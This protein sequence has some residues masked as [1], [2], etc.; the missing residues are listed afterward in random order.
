MR[1]FGELYGRLDSTTS[2]NA[3]VDHLVDYFEAAPAADAAWAVYVLTGR[4]L[5]RPITTTQMRAWT[6]D[7]AGVPEWLFEECYIKVGDLAETI[8]LLLDEGSETEDR[9]DDPLHAW[10]ED[11]IP[12][13]ENASETRQR[14]LVTDWW[15]GLDRMGT[16]VL[17]KLMMGAFRVGVASGLVTRA[18]S[19]FGGVD[20]PVIQHRLA[21][22]WEPSA[23]YFER[24]VSE[25]TGESDR[26]RPY[27]YFLATPMDQMAGD[28]ADEDPDDWLVEW[29][30]DGIRAQLVV[31]EGD[32]YLWSRGQE[33]ITDTYPE[34]RD[35]AHLLDG[36]VVLDGELLAW[37]DGEPLPF[38][39]LQHRIGRKQV[40]RSIR[41]K[42]PVVFMAYDIPERVGED[43]RGMPVEARRRLLESVL[44]G[45]PD[46]FRASP[47]V[48]EPTWEAYA[49]RREEAR[50]RRV[51]GL[52]LKR[53]GSPYRAGRK[54]GDW[55]KWKVDPFTLDGVLLYAKAGH[56]WR[57][58]LYTDLTFGVWDGDELV[59]ICKAYSGLSEDEIEE[60]DDWI[61]SHTIERFGPV[62]SIEH[63]HVFEIAFAGLAP[64][65][66]H[67]SGIALRFP[68]INRWRRGLDIDQA[69]DLEDVESLLEE[70]HVTPDRDEPEQ[71]SLFEKESG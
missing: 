67:K 16:F 61:K 57:A 8:A 15:N 44:D 54:R 68:R 59:P 7:L 43:I 29:K 4:N 21:G 22:E 39:E 65:N 37:R 5:S 41:R 24:L 32:V 18:L 48:D 63:E 56:G 30:W 60:L 42:V 34:I 25:E 19:E 9:F 10:I 36:A 31:R 23:S 52:M 38:S 11:R 3:K 14:E 58:D 51:E 64:S 6:Y 35:A 1:Q 28:L 20:R 49:E 27:P 69:D 45:A 12:K 13:L 71:Q 2:T 33:L 46:P 26:S 66:R 70:Y 53:I 47:L 17:N 50:D 55:W 62:R 40:P